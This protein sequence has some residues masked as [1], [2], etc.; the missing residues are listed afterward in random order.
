MSKV[1]KKNSTTIIS[2]L[3]PLFYTLINLPTLLDVSKIN[4]TT[5]F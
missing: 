3:V 4:K 5:K 1:K 2:K